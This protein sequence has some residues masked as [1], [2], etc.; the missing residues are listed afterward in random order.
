MI[1]SNFA[2]ESFI[3]RSEE[4]FMLYDKS[5]FGERKRDY[6]EYAPI[7]A[8]FLIEQEKMRVMKN[9]KEISFDSL[10]KKLSKVDKKISTKL[11]VYSDLRKRGYI[12]NTALK[13][14]AEFRVYDKGYRPGAAHAR[15]ILYTAKEYEK[16]S[17]HDFAAKNRIAHS[18]AKSCQLSLMTKE[19]FH[20]MKSHG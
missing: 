13:F 19:T 11:A 18:A 1:N 9:S 6:V 10:M 14:G 12:V 20:I 7:E 8:L 17:W 4:S 15:W 5:L 2:N 3:S 16:L